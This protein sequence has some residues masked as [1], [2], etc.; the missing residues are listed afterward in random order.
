M[1]I[2]PDSERILS[3][4]QKKMLFFI[5]QEEKVARDVYSTLA[6]IYQNKNIF[7]LIQSAEQR[8]VDFAR[9]L[10]N[11]YGLN[12]SDLNGDT[13][14]EFESPVLQTLYNACIEKGEISFFDALEVGEFIEAGNIEDLGQASIGMS[15]EVAEAYKKLQKSNLTHLN[16]FRTARSRAA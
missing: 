5:Y 11:I 14:G 4:D 10:C 6:K 16:A 1:S 12:I 3:E 15:S 2:K 8:H 13:V 7:K 9:E